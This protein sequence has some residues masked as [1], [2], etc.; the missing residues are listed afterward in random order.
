MEQDAPPHR[1]WADLDAGVLSRIA[2]CFDFRDYAF[3][4]VVCTSWRSA[5]PPPDSRPFAPVFPAPGDSNSTDAAG[6]ARVLRRLPSRLAPI[7]RCI[8]ARD[9]W[10]ALALG[11][12]GPGAGGL[13]VSLFNPVTGAEIPLDASLCDLRL[14][15]V[16]EHWAPKVVFAPSPSACD[17]TAVGIC[18][19]KRLAVQRSC[20]DGK[21]GYISQAID[22]DDDFM[23]GAFLADI[24]YRDDGDTVYCLTSRG[25]VHVLRLN[26]RRRRRGCSARAVEVRPLM[27]KGNDNLV[28]CDGVLYQIWRRP[29][30]AGS[31]DVPAED[32]AWPRK[33]IRIQE[34]DVFVR[35]YDPGRWPYWAEAQDLGGN[36]VFVGMNDAAAVRGGDG[37]TAL[38]GNCV[39]YWDRRAG[40]DYEAVVFDMATGSSARWLPANEA[41]SSPLWYFLPAGRRHVE[42]TTEE[43]TGLEVP[44]PDNITV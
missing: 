36:A 38:R 6:Q 39:Y 23:H 16:Y 20:G 32:G 9:G 14:G 42:P 12:A 33:A 22:T 35:R 4:R 3:F 41:V 44:C 43:D 28:L 29:R 21:G 26:R 10:V 37:A 1:R 17:F 18:G 13:K 25:G 19:P 5:L 40:G 34:G 7:S 15:G 31:V 24:A 30:G 27:G 8:G 2:Y 11:T